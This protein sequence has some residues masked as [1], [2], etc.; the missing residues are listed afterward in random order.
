MDTLEAI[1]TKR[2]VRH[3]ADR[4]IADADLRAILNA[5]RRSQSSKNSQPWVFIAV[6]DRETLQ[7]LADCGPFAKHLV[8]AAAAIALVSLNPTDFDLGQAAAYIQLAAW[9]LGIGSCI[10]SMYEQDKA[11]QILGIPAEYHFDIT[12]S[13][14][15][16]DPNVARPARPRLTGRKP[17]DEVVRFERW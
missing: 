3:F 11:K 13:L 4:P 10:G 14:G 16:P 1:R 15:Y 6:R 8:G 12:L 5:G 2:A 17:F 7:K 9:D